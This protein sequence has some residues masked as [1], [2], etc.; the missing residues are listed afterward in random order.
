MGS[1]VK[2][3]YVKACSKQSVPTEIQPAHMFVSTGIKS[4]I[5]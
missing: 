4:I 1:L 3:M 5:A 2:Y